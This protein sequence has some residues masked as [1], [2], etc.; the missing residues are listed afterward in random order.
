MAY[1][2]AYSAALTKPCVIIRNADNNSCAKKPDFFK[3][4]WVKTPA[5][6][7]EIPSD[8]VDGG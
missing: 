3:V 5:L 6:T 7:V 8:A 2:T 1:E 4:P